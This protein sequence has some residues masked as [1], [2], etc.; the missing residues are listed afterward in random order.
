MNLVLLVNKINC[1]Y[2]IRFYNRLAIAILFLKRN[3][4]IIDNLLFFSERPFNFFKFNRVVYI[5]FFYYMLNVK[6]FLLFEKNKTL[7]KMTRLCLALH[8][9][10][11]FVYYTTGKK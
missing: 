1:R 7:F 2:V 5:V 4:I 6:N 9:L 8:D 3:Q 11:I 10:I